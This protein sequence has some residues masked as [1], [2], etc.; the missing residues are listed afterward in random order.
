MD[1]IE[2]MEVMWF[3]ILKSIIYMKTNGHS[4]WKLKRIE[5]GFKHIIE[6]GDLILKDTS[7]AHLEF[8]IKL[9]DDDAYQI[10]MSATYLFGQLSFNSSKALEILETRIATDCNWRVQEMLA[11]A[12]D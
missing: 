2:E 10:R 4:H 8:G 1:Q 11:T 7:I 3:K 12:F 9:L 5:H 6:A